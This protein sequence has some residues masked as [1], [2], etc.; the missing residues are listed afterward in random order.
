MWYLIDF[1]HFYYNINLRYLF[2]SKCILESI[3][4]LLN[5]N[6]P[7]NV[8]EL[9][10]I[11]ERACTLADGEFIEPSDLQLNTA[12]LDIPK[13]RIEIPRNEIEGFESNA[14]S[15]MHQNEAANEKDQIIDALNKTRWN[16]TAAAKTLGMTFRQLRYRIK[17]YEL[18]QKL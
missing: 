11:L 16:R 12:N 13:P 4:A 18:D 15:N 17:K 2:L 14:I 1:K 9:E 3:F 6:F 8:R 10:N 5:Y 7:G